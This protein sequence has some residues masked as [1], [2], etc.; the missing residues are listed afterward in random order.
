[1][2]KLVVCITGG[3]ASGK[4]Q[5]SNLF[6]EYGCQIIDADIVAREVVAVDSPGWRLILKYFG[7]DILT[8]AGEINRQQLR[9]IVFR[10][11]SLR[12]QLNAITHPLIQESIGQQVRAVS[13]GLLFLVIPLL[14]EDNRY[15]IIDRVLVVDVNPE[16][17]LKRLRQRD[18]TT[19][20]L[21]ETM[22]ASQI[23]RQQRIH[24]ADDI[25]CNNQDLIKLA[26]RSEVLH[27]FYGSLV[28]Y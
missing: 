6:A 10:D 19:L 26:L 13:A 2:R 8:D 1:M 9:Q 22:I 3:I 5:V 28:R 12:K 15:P 21:A 23:T 25:I 17:Q 18:V 7:T 24:L 11:D 4:T 14:T 27:S 16:L 20:A